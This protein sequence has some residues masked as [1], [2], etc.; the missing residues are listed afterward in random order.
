M[1]SQSSLTLLAVV[2]EVISHKSGTED[3]EGNESKQ[4][5]ARVTYDIRKCPGGNSDK[6]IPLIQKFFAGFDCGWRHDDLYSG[7]S[8]ASPRGHRITPCPIQVSLSL[9]M[10]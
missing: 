1:E 5:R 9:A 2:I 3:E 6:F 10:R 8:M 4:K 7:K